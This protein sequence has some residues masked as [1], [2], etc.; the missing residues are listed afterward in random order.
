MKSVR[1]AIRLLISEPHRITSRYRKGQFLPYLLPPY[2]M[3]LY[4]YLRRIL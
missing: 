4:G 1:L 2:V 3:H